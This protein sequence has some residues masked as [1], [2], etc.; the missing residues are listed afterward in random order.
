MPSGVETTQSKLGYTKVAAI[1][2]EIDVYSTSSNQE[3]AA[4]LEANGVEIIATE[5]FSTGD[6]DFTA[7]L[8]KIKDMAPEAVF[9]SA[10]AQEMTEIIKQGRAL[11]IPDT[12]H[13]IVPD[14][15]ESEIQKAGDAAEGAI[16]FT[17]WSSL[18]PAL[19]N[20]EFI[21]NYTMKYGSAPLPW[22]AQ[23]Y[24]ALY[25]LAEAIKNAESK[26][27]AGNSGRTRED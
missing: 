21:E 6:T 9:I 17:G 1:Y 10:L 3:L 24:A 8:T 4:A 7:Q 2:D 18:S 16:A 19:G 15:T 14:L 23:S 11:G 5:T 25:I 27:S 20:Q 22:A 12:V 26:D 13:F